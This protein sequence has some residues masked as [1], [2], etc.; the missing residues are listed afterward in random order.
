MTSAAKSIFPLTISSSE[1]FASS[2]RS[3]FSNCGRL[4]A[5][6]FSSS[7]MASVSFSSSMGFVLSVHFRSMVT[8]PIPR[9][10]CQPP[11]QAVVDAAGG[12]RGV[13]ECDR[14]LVQVGDDVA[15]PVEP[16]DRAALMVVDFQVTLPGVFGPQIHREMRAHL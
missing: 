13:A 3:T 8:H 6:R 5:C 4:A 10:S 15:D 1:A 9:C 16:V 14:D 11:R 7:T 2:A 12:D